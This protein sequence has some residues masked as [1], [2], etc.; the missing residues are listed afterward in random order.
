[1]PKF[2]EPDLCLLE[3][4]TDARLLEDTMEAVRN[5][6]KG[7]F[8]Q[9]LEEVT[10][11]HHELDYSK[12]RFSVGYSG[13]AIGKAAWPKNPNGWPSGF[14]IEKLQLENLASPDSEL[15]CKYI[16]ILHHDPKEVE[17]RLRKEAE[18]VLTKDEFRGTE[19]DSDNK[20]AWLLLSL[21]QSR[22][23]LF[24]LLIKNEARG[25]IDC[26]VAH[27]ERMVKFTSV[28]DEILMTG[29]QGR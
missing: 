2:N 21:E 4:W 20:G 26:M 22:T 23:E 28:V 19:C 1:M 14:Y 9:V 8:D 18:R 29:R 6:Y 7:I 27:F 5:K 10:K 24:D 3:K 13:I 15:P 25:F 17:G 12:T 16:W 11:T